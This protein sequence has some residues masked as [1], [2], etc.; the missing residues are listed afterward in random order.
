MGY[1]IRAGR[2]LDTCA[3][4]V[5]EAAG[6]PYCKTLGSK[7]SSFGAEVL[8][9]RDS[10]QKEND[11]IYHERVLHTDENLPLAEPFVGLQAKVFDLLPPIEAGL[12]L[13][14]K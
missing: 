10:Y 9:K 8:S 11:S 2:L 3:N 12:L 1:L 13:A 6:D 7:V 14:F 4:D 5:L